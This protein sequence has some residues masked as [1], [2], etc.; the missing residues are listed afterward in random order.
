LQKQTLYNKMMHRNFTHGI[1]SC[2]FIHPPPAPQVNSSCPWRRVLPVKQTHPMFV[3]NLFAIY[4][5]WRLINKFTSTRHLS[6]SRTSSIQSVLPHLTSWSRPVSVVTVPYTSSTS[7]HSARQ[8]LDTKKQSALVCN[9]N[10]M[11]LNH[12]ILW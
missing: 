9:L 10:F 1:Q 4:G 8:P 3:I 12:L 6:L 11:Q 5:T 2:L 7:K